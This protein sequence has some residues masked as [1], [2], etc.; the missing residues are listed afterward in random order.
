MAPLISR[1]MS[2]PTS[3][4]RVASTVVPSDVS[5][6]CL[7]LSG[8]KGNAAPRRS[9]IIFDVKPFSETVKNDP[10]LW[11]MVEQVRQ[12]G[13]NAFW[14]NDCLLE[15]NKK[16]GWRLN[17]IGEPRDVGDEVFGF[18]IY[19]VDSGHKV[20][21]LQYIAV[22]EKH[23]RHGIG[24]KLIRS[25]QQFATKTLTRSM[26]EKIACACVPEA[27]EFY[28]KHC[29]RKG[30]RIVPDEEEPTEDTPDNLTKDVQIPVQFQMEW[31]VPRHGMNSKRK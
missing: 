1:G 9:E 15:C 16:N 6:C 3:L 24:S 2:S 12:I 17:I 18:M 23:R 22:A 28:Q 5:E 13:S 29:F 27:V 26:T 10:R 11:F 4:F 19:K 30:K 20:L 8:P 14:G 21:H 7:S 31:K 25:L